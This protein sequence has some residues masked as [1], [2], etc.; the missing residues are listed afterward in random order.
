MFVAGGGRHLG[1]FIAA[2][3]ESPHLSFSEKLMVTDLNFTIVEST[4]EAVFHSR[5][6]SISTSKIKKTGLNPAA[7][8]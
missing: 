8:R 4:P 2:T 7:G 6:S 5:C 1:T 3:L